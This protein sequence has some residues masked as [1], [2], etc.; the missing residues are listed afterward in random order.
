VAENVKASRATVAGLKSDPK[1]ALDSHVT[2][3]P[4]FFDIDM[5][6]RVEPGEVAVRLEGQIGLVPAA[7]S[8]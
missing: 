2:F 7:P 4:A 6:F 1:A 3:E 5:S 8:G